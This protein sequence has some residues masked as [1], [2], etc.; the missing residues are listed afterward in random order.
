VFVT[1]PAE[2]QGQ[3]ISIRYTVI[4]IL[5]Y[6]LLFIILPFISTVYQIVLNN[7]IKNMYVCKNR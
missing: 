4:G 5:F 6:F 3:P 2:L 1:A 7:I